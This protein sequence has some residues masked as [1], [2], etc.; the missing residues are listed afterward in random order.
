MLQC[1]GRNT[2][3]GLGFNCSSVGRA[4]IAGSVR[5]LATLT[6]PAL[7]TE[8]CTLN[9]EHWTLYT[10][11][12]TLNT[13]RWTL[14]TEHCTLYNTKCTLH[15]AHWTLHTVQCTVYTTHWLINT[16]SWTLHTKSHMV[17]VVPVNKTSVKRASQWHQKTSSPKEVSSSLNWGFFLLFL[18]EILHGYSFLAGS[19]GGAPHLQASPACY[20][21]T[22]I[23]V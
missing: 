10:A 7:H 9:T 8:H 16:E 21:R 13:E 17:N 18:Q 11:P 22:S 23:I 19:G 1:S 6:T 5:V 12:S 2:M 15:P 3:V 20:A 4:L 14:Y